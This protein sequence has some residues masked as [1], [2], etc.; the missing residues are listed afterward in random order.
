[1]AKLIAFESSFGFQ[2]EIANKFPLFPKS[3][4]RLGRS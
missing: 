3:L 2:P 1:M 4:M